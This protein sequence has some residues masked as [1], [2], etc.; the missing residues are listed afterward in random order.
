MPSACAHESVL[1][2]CPTE[3]EPAVRVAVPERFIAV[4]VER[5]GEVT[6]R[7]NVVVATPPFPS[8][9]LYPILE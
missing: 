4:G 6:T 1:T 8:S 2:F 9:A 3:S 7:L 5:T